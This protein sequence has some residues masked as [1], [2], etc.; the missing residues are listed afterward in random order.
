MYKKHSSTQ[1]NSLKIILSS[2]TIIA[3]IILSLWLYISK[4]QELNYNN[5]MQ[6]ILQSELDL[7]KESIFF[8]NCDNISSISAKNYCVNQQKSLRDAWKNTTWNEIIS[9][10]EN[11]YKHFPCDALN[12]IESENCTLFKN[13]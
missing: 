12:S 11:V 5:E 10:W 9:Q 7:W 13:N 8:I 6:A 1:N 2:V 4:K 3:I